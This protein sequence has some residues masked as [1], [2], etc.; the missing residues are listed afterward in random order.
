K[1]AYLNAMRLHPKSRRVTVDAALLQ[2]RVDRAF[3]RVVAAL[4]LLSDPR[5]RATYDTALRR[6]AEAPAPPG[7]PTP[8]EVK[9]V[10][11]EP[12]PATRSPGVAPHPPPLDE[13]DTSD[14]RRRRRRFELV[15][16]AEVRGVD[17]VHGRW[18]EAT[19]TTN[20][21]RTGVALALE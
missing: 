8:A 5:K 9:P 19:Q 4:T 16:P 7:T 14:G 3:E 15:L 10:A 1:A 6:P 11:R 12:Q 2:A 17:R 13:R 21:N 18:S 20:A